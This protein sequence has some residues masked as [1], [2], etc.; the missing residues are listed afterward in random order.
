MV[1]TADIQAIFGVENCTLPNSCQPGCL[2]H[3][4]PEHCPC[5]QA[6]MDIR[7]DARIGPMLSASKISRWIEMDDYYFT[8]ARFLDALDWHAENVA[9]EKLGVGM[10]NRPEIDSNGWAARFHALRSAKVT[11]LDVFV[12]PIADEFLTWL[13]R[14][15]TKWQHC[16]NGGILS[17]FEPSADCLPPS[18]K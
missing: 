17:A 11:Q 2:G 15:K 1:V 9:L 18:A 14:W 10:M 7:P 4:Q 16:P 5:E 13:W 8:T 6:P 12:M 3:P